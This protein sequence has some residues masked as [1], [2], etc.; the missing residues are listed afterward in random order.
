[1]SNKE[2][3]LITLEEVL[4][5]FNKQNKEFIDKIK[6]E[7]EFERIETIESIENDIKLQKSQTDRAKD[8]FANSIKNGLGDKVKANP[9]KVTVIKK[10][11]YTKLKESIKKI[12]TKF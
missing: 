3:K 4:D 1:M 12:F 7:E 10:P 11:W 6:N 8:K 5:K 9:N 2:E